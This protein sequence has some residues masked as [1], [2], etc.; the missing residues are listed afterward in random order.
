M[1]KIF[2]T[3]LCLCG[4]A[5]GLDS[6]KYIVLPESAQFKD[7][8]NS[9]VEVFSYG[10]IHC[11]NHHRAGTLAK[12]SKAFA[13]VKVEFWQVEQMGQKGEL[14]VKIL[15]LANALD[16]RNGVS[17]LDNE[18]ISHK[19]LSSY[20]EATFKYKMALSSDEDFASIAIKIFESAGHKAS[21]A[22]IESFAS[23][24][25]GKAY[26]ARLAQGYEVAKMVGTPAFV[27]NGKYI[28]RTEKITSQEDL[29]NSVKEL[30]AM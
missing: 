24:E 13:G 12:L 14:F 23:S 5:W 22:E 18:S 8:Q 10:C 21:L 11:Y 3:L 28:I 25:S 9:I 20:F 7:A 30:L 15:A 19:V 17:P 26:T 1:K 4:F 6:D 29:E 16:M 2:L 27:V